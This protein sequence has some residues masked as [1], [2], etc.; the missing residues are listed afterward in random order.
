MKYFYGKR[1]KSCNTM[2]YKSEITKEQSDNLADNP[3]ITFEF[4]SEDEEVAVIYSCCSYCA[5]DLY[6]DSET[7]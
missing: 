2:Y 6:A 3:N 1:C 5:K 7:T 4:P